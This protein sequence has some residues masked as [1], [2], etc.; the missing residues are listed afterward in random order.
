MFD[1]DAFLQGEITTDID[2][3]GAQADSLFEGLFRFPSSEEHL[4]VFLTNA[5]CSYC[6]GTAMSCYRAYC[7]SKQNDQ[8]LFLLQGEDIETFLFY[9]NKERRR[10]KHHVGESSISIHRINVLQDLPNGL[11][12]VKNGVVMNYYLWQDL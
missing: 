8:L 7:Q 12:L 11:Y 10:L 5:T 6:I 9:Y 2:V 1:F 4:L 3:K